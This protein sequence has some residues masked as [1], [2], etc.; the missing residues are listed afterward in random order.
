M[1]LL[2]PAGSIEAL[3]AAVQSGADAVYIGGSKFSARSS[4]KNFDEHK[5]REMIDYCHIRGVSVHIAANTLIKENE[6]N[7]FLQYIGTLNEMGA[8]AVIIQDIGMAMCVHKMYPDLPI[9]A[10]TQMTCASSKTAKELSQAGFSRIVLARELGYEEIEK[11]AKSVDAEIEVFVHGAICMSYSGQCLMSS[12]I[13]GRSGNRGMCAQPCRL[14]YKFL[15]NGKNVNSGYLLSPK[16]MCLVNHLDK[17]EKIGVASLK[18]EGRLKRAEYVSAVVGVYRNCLDERRKATIDE[19]KELTDAFN[20]SGFTDGYFVNKLG[21]DMMTYENPSN[22][23]Q[24]IF[25]GEAKNRCRDDIELKKVPVKIEAY[26][27][28]D[29]PLVV[30]ITDNDGNT[31]KISGYINSEIANNKP[32]SKERLKE[33]LS[34]LGQTPFIATELDVELD[35]GIIIPVGEINSLRRRATEELIKKRVKNKQR[36]SFECLNNVENIAVFEPVLTAKVRNINQAKICIKKGI[37][38]IYAPYEVIKELAECDVELVQLMPPIDKEG[39]N[40]TNICCN[41]VM[42]NSLGQCAKNDKKYYADYRLNVFNSQTLVTLDE[43]LSVTLSPELT[44][45]EIKRI[46]KPINTEL[47][48]YGRIPLMT[49]EN[50]PVK[51]NSRCDSGKSYNEFVDRKNESFPLICGVG[52]FCEL[53]NSKPL[54]MADKLSDLFDL[55]I[56]FMRLD[57][58]IEDEFECD[59]IISKYQSALKGESVTSLKENT[60]TR[61]HFYRKTD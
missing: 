59:D 4:A 57:F 18:I 2:A 13:G 21:K 16:D 29:K 22:I 60:F 56:K 28:K 14:S 3:I 15:Q 25:S 32:L 7:E 45:S 6:V 46:K 11:I 33:Q 40:N 1:E 54:Y 23:S 5:M 50:C 24:N 47:I 12:M 41:S 35:D 17:L 52:C 36:R 8:D 9:H 44:I 34:K 10:S 39:K 49:F 43:F 48:V 37:K 58:T 19:H 55:D 31:V 61:G 51:A 38:R 20:R 30:V 42:V 53:L 26:L 27:K